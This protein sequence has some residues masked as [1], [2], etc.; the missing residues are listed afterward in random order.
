MKGV[1]ASE[2]LDGIYQEASNKAEIDYWDPYAK[3]IMESIEARHRA[4]MSQQELAVKMSTRQ[5]AISR[6]ENMGRV[7]TYDFI[8]RMAIALGHSPGMTLYGEFMAVV[9][10]KDQGFIA[11]QAAMSGNSTQRFTQELLENAIAGIRT[12][13]IDYNASGTEDPQSSGA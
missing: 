13:K 10:P 2:V 11:A 5:S 7:P 4:S 8:A 9:S 12:V 1:S 6:F 3:L